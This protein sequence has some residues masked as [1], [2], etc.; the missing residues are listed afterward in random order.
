MTGGLCGGQADRLATVAGGAIQPLV[1][2][3]QAVLDGDPDVTREIAGRLQP[4]ALPVLLDLG[5]R[6]ALFC[7]WSAA[8]I[9]IA[10]A[11]FA[12]LLM[13][14]R[15]RNFGSGTVDAAEFCG[16]V[17]TASGSADV[18]PDWTD[19][20]S[21]VLVETAG[22]PVPCSATISPKRSSAAITRWAGPP[23]VNEALPTLTL[24]SRCSFSSDI[25][26]QDDSRAGQPLRFG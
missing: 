5:R 20:A 3:Q 1:P 7:S 6:R 12:L 9:T 11:I 2:G 17:A 24:R 15:S 16:G 8:Q 22:D 10:V 4:R 19:S 26:R 18:P 21:S 13:P 25:A 14:P 23:P